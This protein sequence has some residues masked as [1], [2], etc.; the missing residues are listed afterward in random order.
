LKPANVRLTTDG[1][2]KVLDFG[3]AI[4]LETSAGAS[5]TIS[6][7]ETT[8][9]VGT[10]YYMA[11]EVLEGE[12]ADERSD[13]YS[14]GVVL[15]EMATGRRPF[16]GPNAMAV[17]YAVANQTP[18]PPREVAPGLSTALE[19]VIQKAIDRD[20]ARRFQSVDEFLTVLGELQS[21]R[22]PSLGAAPGGPVRS[23][24]V[25]PLENLSGQESE[26][27]FAD[28]MTE[29]LIA[30]LV[31]AG[32]IRVISRT[33]AMAYK[34]VRKPLP[35]IAQELNVDA[36]VEGSVLRSGDRVRITAQ[37]IQA[38]TDLHL[39]AESYEREIHDVLSL[40]SEVAQAIAEEILG[41]LSPRAKERL[42]RSRVDPGAYEA[43]LRGR[44]HWNRR[45]E[46][47]LKHGLVF[48]NQ[49]IEKDPHYALAYV[50]L[51]DTY[52]ILGFYSYLPSREAFPRAKAAA[53]KALEMDEDLAE[54]HVSLAYAIHFYDWNWQDA[55]SEYTTA[56]EQVPNY[57]L[58][59]H[60]YFNYLVSMGRLDEAIAEAKKALELDPLSLVAT[61][62]LGWVYYHARDYDRA[63]EQCRKACEMDRT[64]A[65]AGLWG[66]L[67]YQAKGMHEEALAGF[68][69]ATVYAGRSPITEAFL[70]HGEALAG[71]PS[72]ARRILD[73]L[74][75]TSKSRHIPSYVIALVW[76]GLGDTDRAFEW[77]DR[78]YQ[79]R[80]HW[81]VFLNVD[82]R[83]DDLRGDPRFDALRQQVGL[84]T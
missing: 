56:L 29:A 41:T 66:G 38:R 69:E 82:P 49:A 8:E 27:F 70:A 31:K 48:F 30:D 44:F 16:Q 1:R 79:R 46:D 26:E 43:Y 64:F 19:E 65:W 11:P 58:A 2:L 50:G 13:L 51:A 15:Y 12:P 62:G 76:H 18:R 59:H 40:Q 81:L 73:E 7:A 80:S 61:A 9:K 78:A 23:L 35:L 28:G 10:P 36:V 84:G 5:A 20:P 57:A 47:A 45:T 83:L 33:S 71:N 24:V 32:G 25:L 52:N 75:E 14:L 42:T 60:W 3:L 34:G 53:V 54:A 22:V 6:M 21:G 63:I 37:L 17:I 77:L 4:L 72:D 74:M 68:R 55:E 67:A 39:W